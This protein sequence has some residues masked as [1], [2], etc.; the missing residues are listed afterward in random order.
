M[1]FGIWCRNFIVKIFYK[2]KIFIY[3][4]N[5]TSFPYIQTL[6][7]C[8]KIHSTNH[9]LFPWCNDILCQTNVLSVQFKLHQLH[10]KPR[11]VFCS[12]THCDVC[13]PANLHILPHCLSKVSKPTENK[14]TN[15]L[16]F[17]A[18]FEWWW[19]HES[20]LETLKNIKKH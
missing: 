7:I 18:P 2:G 14:P 19:A 4:F 11:Q 17:A 16:N 9:L 20:P 13:D 1:L 10:L 12:K 5:A 6:L 8:C 3:S 15:A